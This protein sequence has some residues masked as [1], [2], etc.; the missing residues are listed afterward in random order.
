M[1]GSHLIKHGRSG[2]RLHKIW[3]SM[4]NRCYNERD[5]SYKNYGA[6][7]IAVCE[8]WKNDFCSFKE[9]ALANGYDDKLSIDRINVN[10]NYEPDNCRWATRKTQANNTT[11]NHYLTIGGIT[12]TMREWA[13]HYKIPYST[14][15][16]RIMRSNGNVEK[17]INNNAYMGRCGERYISYKDSTKRYRV[18]IPKLKIDNTFGT[19]EEAKLY[20]DNILDGTK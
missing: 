8:E 20:R 3:K 14:F 11:R 1:K 15:R 13:E 2:E 19:I 9:W 10:G 6:R 18:S 4:K 7:G 12:K 16:A 17:A 5:M